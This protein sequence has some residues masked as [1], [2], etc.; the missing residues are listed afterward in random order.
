[1]LVLTGSDEKLLS[2]G[3]CIEL[4]AYKQKCRKTLQ[5]IGQWCSYQLKKM[6]V[7]AQVPEG[8]FYIFP[9]FA[10]RRKSLARRGITTDV[11]LCESLL[12]D[13]GVAILPGSCFG[14]A[15]EELYARIAFVDFKGEIALYLVE[16]T[17]CYKI[18]YTCF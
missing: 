13:T 15:P 8:G 1:M 5:I 6:C 4:D 3:S 17:V 9:C 12:H 16:S 2:L 7:E 10:S 14:R 11:E 18:S